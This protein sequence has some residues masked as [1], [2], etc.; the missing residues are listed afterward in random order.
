MKIY[1]LVYKVKKNFLK[2]YEKAHE[3]IW[4]EMNEEIS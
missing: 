4:P 1:G 2:I 3:E